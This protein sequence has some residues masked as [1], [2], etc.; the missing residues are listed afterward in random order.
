VFT[1]VLVL[2]SRRVRLTPSE[3]HELEAAEGVTGTISRS[4]E[5]GRLALGIIV[6]IIGANL[7]VEGAA[8]IAR[9]LGVSELVIGLTLVSVGTSL[10]ELT[11]ALIAA[12]RRENDILFGNLIGSNIFNL[13]GILAITAVVQPVPI[14]A[15]VIQFDLIIMI[16]FA[17]LLVLFSLNRL[18][19]RREAAII[20]MAYAAFV[21]FT[22]SR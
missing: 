7:L 20:L 22:F 12:V 5:V 9:G 10:P 14:D 6:L 8:S 3:E 4:R 11:T 21:L 17:V 19:L 16:A 15:Q 13:L 2:V 18:L 1:G